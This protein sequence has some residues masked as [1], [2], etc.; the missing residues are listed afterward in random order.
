LS[1]DGKPLRASIVTG[2]MFVVMAAALAWAGWAVR[3]TTSDNSRVLCD[4]LAIGRQAR[5]ER[6]AVTEGTVD[7]LQMELDRINDLYDRISEPIRD[8]DVRRTVTNR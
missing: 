5:I 3:N 6:L 7:Q 2:V 1:D 4:V 8:C